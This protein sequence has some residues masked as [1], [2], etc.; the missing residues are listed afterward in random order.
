MIYD[1]ENFAHQGL[2]CFLLMR[3]TTITM[4]IVVLLNVHCSSEGEDSINFNL[5]F[6]G[7]MIRKHMYICAF[8]GNI[9]VSLKTIQASL[10]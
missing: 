1:I 7:G 5:H 10:S 9:H 3:T 4:Q 8:P 2:H 6:D